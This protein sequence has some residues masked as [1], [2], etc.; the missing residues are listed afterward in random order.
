M[1]W[2][3]AEIS[4]WNQLM[5]STLELLKLK[6]KTEEVFDEQ[7]RMN[8]TDAQRSSCLQRSL[9]FSLRHPTPAYPIRTTCG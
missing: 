6:L 9:A 8:D 3:S 4:H 2:P 7:H 5:S 1:I